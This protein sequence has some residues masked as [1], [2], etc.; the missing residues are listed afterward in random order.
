MAKEGGDGLVVASA[1]DAA[2]GKAVAEG[3]EA[4]GRNPQSSQEFPVVG[5]IVPRLVRGGGVG[6]QEMGG[7]YQSAQGPEHAEEGG[8]QGNV[9][10]A[11][12]G[13]GRV[14]EEEVLADAVI[15]KGDAL[16]GFAHVENAGFKVKV[17][18]LEGADFPNPKAGVQADED[19]QIL[20]GKVLTEM[21]QKPFL[22]VVR[23]RCR[24]TLLLGLGG[25]SYAAVYGWPCV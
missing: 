8:R 25:E 7:V 15:G 11:G 13:F 6:D 23:E 16:D 24:R 2:G 5:P 4:E 22:L 1:L 12:W 21:L 9:P 19:A 17:L 20:E 14:D 3:V 10:E 18:P